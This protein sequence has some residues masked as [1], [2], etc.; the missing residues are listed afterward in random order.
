MFLPA[1]EYSLEAIGVSARKADRANEKVNCVN[2]QHSSS[3]PEI[4]IETRKN[5]PIGNSFLNKI[6]V[7]N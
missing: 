1:E 5:S 7:D 2:C 6:V 3:D 4:S